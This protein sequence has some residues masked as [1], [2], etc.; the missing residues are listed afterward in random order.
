M[1]FWT[2]CRTGF[3]LRTLAV[4][5]L[6]LLVGTVFK[7]HADW[8]LIWS[9]EFNGSSLN[10]NVWWCEL[11]P[12]PCIN[13]NNELEIY[14]NAPQNVYVSNGMLH[15]VAQNIGSGT[16]YLFTSG[17]LITW[18]IDD[19]SGNIIS[20]MTPFAFCHGAIEFR[21]TL[22]Q[23]VGLWPALW[24]LPFEQ[25]TGGKNPIFGNW[26]NSG[27][28]DVMENNGQEPNQV[29]Q[30]LHYYNGAFQSTGLVNDVTQWHVYRLEWYTNQF[31]WMVDGVTT[32][33]TSTWNPP[34]GYSYP[35]PFTTNFYIIMNLAVGGDYTGNPSAAT[36]ATNLP[37]EMDI[38][39][40]RV[41]AQI[42]PVLFVAQTN[43]SFF[44]SWL[45]QPAAWVLD[46][47]T[48]FGN[49]WTQ[50]PPATYQTN[51]NQIDFSVPAPLSNSI[52]FRLRQQ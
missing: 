11:G 36:V 28:I 23:G 5:W 15:I 50:V 4:L 33:T 35:T 12:G 52:F 49:A 51:G 13:N 1:G 6:V 32:S 34:P 7:A 16:N 19:C 46:Q 22:P 27:E 24:L 20:N 41:Y 8:Q 18:N 37:A 31:N 17:R 3:S 30:N 39:Y 38:D 42:N 9:D 44:V 2:E 43:G 21:A 40:V 26:P 29:G 10:T 14:T 47:T 25:Y 48:A 45:Q